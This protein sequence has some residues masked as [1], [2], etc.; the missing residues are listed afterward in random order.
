MEENDGNI[1][2]HEGTSKDQGQKSIKKV[3]ELR[4]LDSLKK[5][6]EQF[7]GCSQLSTFMKA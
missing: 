4:S 6:Q 3:G 7:R 5:K 2:R 1:V